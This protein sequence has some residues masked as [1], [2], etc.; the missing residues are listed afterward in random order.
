MHWEGVPLGEFYAL[1]AAVTWACALVL[2][3]RSGEKVSPLALNLFKNGIAIVLLAVTLAVIGQGVGTLLAFPARDIWILILSGFLGI[4][5]ADT[6]FFRALNLIG[7]GFI[8]V[9][10]CLYSPFVILFAAVLLHEDLTV[11]HYVGGGLIV[12]GVLISSRHAPPADRTRGQLALGVLLGAT[13]IALMAFGIVIAKESL[14]GFALIWATM[15]RVLVGTGVLALAAAISP[16][17]RAYWSVFRPS[18]VWKYSI[19][20]SVLG[21]YLAMIFW[22]AGFKYTEAS[23]AGILNQTSVV[24]AIILATVFL[25]ERLTKRKMVSVAL[26]ASGAVLVALNPFRTS[27]PEAQHPSTQP[28]SA[29]HEVTLVSPVDRQPTPSQD[30]PD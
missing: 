6:I 26:A 24:F 22:V 2:F 29:H 12:A 14:E 19:P 18:A 25:K 21:A 11:P 1:M 28:R 10:D 5:L 27:P 20:A 16:K 9:V 15:L 17:R 4:A 23:I 13:A 8:S 30:G 3:K 7:V